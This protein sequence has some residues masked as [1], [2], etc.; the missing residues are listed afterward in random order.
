MSDQAPH[1]LGWSLPPGTG[2]C[3]INLDS[4]PDRWK[5]FQ[6][7][8]S[9]KLG[10]LPVERIPAILGTALEGFGKAPFFRGRKRD[11]TWAARGGCVLSH[12]S[13][14]LHAH[15]MGWSHV[16]ILEDDVVLDAA[17]TEEL[18]ESL[19]EAIIGAA[20]DVCY[21][22]FTDPVPPF[23]KISDIAPGRGM[24]RVFGCNTA[25]A[26]LVNRRAVNWILKRLPEPGD[27]WPWLTRHR[28][29]D[30]F[31]YRNLSPEL[32][33]SA[34]SPALITQKEGFSDIVG[35]TVEVHAGRHLTVVPDGETAAADFPKA[36]LA[37]AGRFRW[38]GFFDAFRGFLKRRRGF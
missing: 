2:V 8:V 20:P 1:N 36:Q 26:Y 17:L 9:D 13:A 35:K 29:V 21:L 34:V 24:F 18:S 14:L 28:A 23:R 15:A 3:V 25:H 12:R 27:I 31:Y 37:T 38:E 4:R 16:L 33:V 6:E 32:V 22:G 19:R 7:N 30:R 10:N 11:S 5:E